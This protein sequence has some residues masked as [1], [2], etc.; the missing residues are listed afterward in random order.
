M[1]KKELLEIK[2]KT[3]ENLRLLLVEKKKA[4]VSMTMEQKLGKVKNVHSAHQIKKDIA[5]VKTILA[6]KMF[7]ERVKNEE[8]K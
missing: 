8:T 6:E 3:I 7:A 4:Q 1:K 5:E 2:N